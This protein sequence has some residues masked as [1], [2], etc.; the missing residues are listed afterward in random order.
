M[1]KLGI[2]SLIAA[3]FLVMALTVQ[4][5]KPVVIIKKYEVSVSEIERERFEAQSELI[6]KKD[7]M[8][9]DEVYFDL[10]GTQPFE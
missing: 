2:I 8:V 3:P 4:Q 9:C 5:Q 6:V 1:K 10:R 7:Y